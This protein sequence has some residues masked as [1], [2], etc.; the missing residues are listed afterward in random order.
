MSTGDL[1]SLYNCREI[2]YLFQCNVTRLNKADGR[3]LL[4]P[5]SFRRETMKVIGASTL[6]YAIGHG[7]RGYVV[8]GSGALPRP[9]HISAFPH[10]T[11]LGSTE[12]FLTQ[13]S[14]GQ[15]AAGVE[16]HCLG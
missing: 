12:V 10:I 2:L 8:S 1:P 3:S 16:S 6:D 5:K 11:P 13:S 7:K 9:F 4:S 15:S 14:R